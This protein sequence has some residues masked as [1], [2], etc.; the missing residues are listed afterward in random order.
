MGSALHALHESKG[1]K[2]RLQRSVAKFEG[3]K[4]TGVKT[5]VLDNGDRL[6]YAP[7]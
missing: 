3:D 4:T 1:V 6:V 2:F 7:P 5:V